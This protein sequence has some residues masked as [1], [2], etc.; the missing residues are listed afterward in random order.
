MIYC[1]NFNLQERNVYPQVPSY[2]VTFFS[3]ISKKIS[4]ARLKLAHVLLVLVAYN[5]KGT[6]NPKGALSC[7][8]RLNKEES[9]P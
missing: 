2:V 8:M 6:H 5:T 9:S 4:L 3:D 1:S 7:K